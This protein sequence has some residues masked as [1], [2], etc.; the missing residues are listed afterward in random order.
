MTIPDLRFTTGNSAMGHMSSLED[1]RISDEKCFFSSHKMSVPPTPKCLC[2]IGI[3]FHKTPTTEGRVLWEYCLKPSKW[4][5]FHPMRPRY[6]KG[7][8]TSRTCHWVLSYGSSASGLRL[9]NDHAVVVHSQGRELAEYSNHEPRNV[10]PNFETWTRW[11]K[12]SCKS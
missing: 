9:S 1:G 8:P 7:Q 11:Q 4:K 6:T 10:L 3:H 5:H 12:N 2:S